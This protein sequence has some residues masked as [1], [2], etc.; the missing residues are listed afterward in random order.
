MIKD[1]GLHGVIGP[2]EFFSYVSGAD[3]KGSYFYEDSPSNIRFFSK[4]NEFVISEEGIRYK[5]TGG[6]FCE[7]MFGVEKPLKDLM[8]KEVLNRLIMFGAFSDKSE[9]VV[10][11]NNTEGLDTFGRLFM[12]GHAVKNYYFFISS[13]Y[14]GEIKHRQKQILGAVGKLLKRTEHPT[15]NR[16]SEL[17]AAFVKELREPQSTVLMFKLVHKGN[18]EFYRVFKEFYFNDKAIS[19]KEDMFIKEIALKSG[20]DYYQQERMK[21]DIMYRHPENRSI[22]DE[23]RD[24]LLSSMKSDTLKRSEHARLR[25]LRTL[26]VRYNIPSVLFE[27]LDEFLLKGKKIQETAEPEYLHEARAI[28]ENLFFKD[29]SLKR[30]IINEDI[31]RLIRAKHMAYTNGDMGF[32][33]IL[34]DIGKACD[35][36]ARETGDYSLLEDFSS[37][38]TYFDRY[39]HVQASMNQIAF[40]E[41]LDLNDNF[42]RS[43]LGNMKEF[44]DLE[45]KLFGELFVDSL[46]GN[47]YITGYGRKK[48]KAVADGLKKVQA[49]DASLKDIVIKLKGIAD[50]ER[51]YRHAHTL[52]KERLHG[53]YS[54]LDIK[55]VREDIKKETE[56]ELEAKELA[57]KVPDSIFEKVFLD[58]K[59]EAFYL[60]NLLPSIIKKVDGGLREDFLKNSGLD[61]FYI[62]NLEKEYFD[63]NGLDMFLLDLIREDKE[64][65]KTLS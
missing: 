44:N 53:F 42:L 29:P 8:N 18:K 21:I 2:V 12:Q 30:H 61:R 27:T 64:I 14:K 55:E 39:D 45:T 47:K 49:G 24:I 63:E 9:K 7:Y 28:L 19:G 51:L 34:L 11:T 50:E 32:E 40:M 41:N 26:R 52:L 38:V 16:D 37:I 43:M 58:L 15:E 60:N 3:A 48:V 35:E 17:M 62:E 20:I 57:R 6:N 13:D 56:F 10:F 23:Y 4:G 54:R 22:V 25:R 1:L 33:Q 65:A 36:T 5:G 59:K 46:F 31:A